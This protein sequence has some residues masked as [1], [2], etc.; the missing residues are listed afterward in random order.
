MICQARNR[1]RQRICLTGSAHGQ[2]A[3]CPICVQRNGALWDRLVAEE[4]LDLALDEAIA[5]T[6]AF[7]ERIDAAS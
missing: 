6:S 4:G 5:A 2:P 3:C 7:V 1:P